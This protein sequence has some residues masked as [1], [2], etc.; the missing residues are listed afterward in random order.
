VTIVFVAPH[1]SEHTRRWVAFFAERGHDV[2]DVTCGDTPPGADAPRGRYTVPDLGRPRPG[3][4]G[5]VLALRRARTLIRALR[6]DIVHAHHATSYGL[7]GAGA[8]IHPFVVTCH[9]T[10]VLG[11]PRNPV[12]RHVVARTLRAA[13]LITVPGDHMRPVVERLAGHDARVAVFQYGVVVDELEAVAA[14]ASRSSADAGQLRVVTARP[15]EPHYHTSL[16]IEAVAELVARGR[17]CVYDVAGAGSDRS[18]LEHV[19]EAAGVAG[20]VRFH[21]RLA[22]AETQRLLAAADA[23]VSIAASD[24]VSIALLEAMALGPIPVVADIVSNREW[25]RDRENG[26]LVDITS[27]AVADG[28]DAAVSLDRE[29]VRRRNLELVRARADRFTNLARCEAL[30]VE[31]VQAAG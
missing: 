1:A 17:D 18:R 5:Y 4:L 19:A 12:L 10:D 16:V 22:E 24:G 31:L 20:R 27:G 21:G 14:A 28:I 15:L 2:H 9:G 8:G 11:S 13:D 29:V 25:I 23:Y 30:L 7:L 6:P 3:Q 26:V